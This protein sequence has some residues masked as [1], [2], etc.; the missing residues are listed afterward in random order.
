MSRAVLLLALCA[1]LPACKHHRL[2]APNDFVVLE[3]SEPYATRAVSAQ[4]VAI[5]VREIDNDPRANSAFWLSA[6]RTQLIDG[7]GYALLEARDVR[8]RSGQP[9]KQLRLGRDQNGEQYLYWLTLFVTKHRLYIVEAGARR[10][11][12]EQAQKQV[13]ASLASLELK[14]TTP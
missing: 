13:D 11:R 4:G 7:R 8:A 10:D 2:R 9:G 6:I 14:G 3:D 12:F 1:L 5:G